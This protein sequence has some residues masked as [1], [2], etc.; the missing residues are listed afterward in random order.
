M[1][2][3]FKSKKPTRYDIWSSEVRL[4]DISPTRRG[5]VMR[6]LAQLEKEGFDEQAVS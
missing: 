5:K 6:L 3:V 4:K 2:K 1:R